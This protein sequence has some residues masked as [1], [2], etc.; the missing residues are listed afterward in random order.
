ML[1]R[2]S[3]NLQHA[4]VTFYFGMGGKRIPINTNLKQTNERTPKQI[5]ATVDIKSTI[6]RYD[7]F[8]VRPD[9]PAVAKG[10]FTHIDGSLPEK[11]VSERR[12]NEGKDAHK[13]R[14]DIWQAVTRQMF[15]G[16][17]MS[18]QKIR[19]SDDY[20]EMERASPAEQC[21]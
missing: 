5:M 11:L 15:T 4:G 21:S 14:K 9:S 10:H 1:Y 6:K 8:Q 12:P 7:Q 3:E 13:Y 16:V 19:K 2:S 18:L 20:V 17:I